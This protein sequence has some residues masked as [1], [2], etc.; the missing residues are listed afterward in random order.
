MWDLWGLSG[1]HTQRQQALQHFLTCHSVLNFLNLLPPPGSFPDYMPPVAFLPWLPCHVT[2]HGP[3]L[4][5]LRV[6]E[7]QCSLLKGSAQSPRCFWGSRAQGQG[8]SSES[9]LRPVLQLEIQRA[10]SLAGTQTQ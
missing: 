7:V 1:A 10:R 4:V 3:V 8:P 9:A 2:V 5:V 6:L